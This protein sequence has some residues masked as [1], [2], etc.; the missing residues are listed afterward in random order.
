MMPS[1]A[2]LNHRGIKDLLSGLGAIDPEVKLLQLVID[3]IIHTARLLTRRCN[4]CP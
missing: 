3:N 4:V 2:S 1:I